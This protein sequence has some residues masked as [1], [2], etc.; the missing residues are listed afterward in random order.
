MANKLT[1]LTTFQFPL[2]FSIVSYILLLAGIG[3]GL[4]RFNENANKEKKKIVQMILITCSV[5]S[6]ANVN[7][8]MKEHSNYWMSSNPAQGG[9]NTP[10]VFV[11]DP[12]QFRSMIKDKDLSK[13]LNVIKKGTPDY[14]ALSKN[15]STESIYKKEPYKIYEHDVIENPNNVKKSVTYD[16][17]LKLEW[18]SENSEEVILP[19]AIYG[20]S[21]IKMNGQNKSPNEVGKSDLG[22]LEVNSLVGN[23]TVIV[24]YTP[25]IN[26]KLIITIKVFGLIFCC[27]NLVNYFSFKRYRKKT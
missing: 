15:E 23:N 25:M 10:N 12:N 7:N 26:M 8:L 2:R 1:F 17:K 5:F 19:V 14:L 9:N 3:L 22:L 20:N 13:A 24:G 16:S 27:I 11:T 4:N 21:T 6:I 18:N